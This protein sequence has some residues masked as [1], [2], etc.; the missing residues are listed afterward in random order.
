M[1]DEQEKANAAFLRQRRNLIAGALLILFLETTVSPP[2]E[3]H[4]TGIT[5]RITHAEYVIYWIW[6]FTT[7]WLL[8][9][10]QYL[11]PIVDI[12][13][14]TKFEHEKSLKRLLLRMANK[15][16]LGAGGKSD[17]ETY[18]YSLQEPDLLIS[19]HGITHLSVAYKSVFFE[20]KADGSRGRTAIKGG[21]PSFRL[22]FLQ[23]LYFNV[24]AAIATAVRTPL[25]TD[26]V[27]PILLFLGGAL[28]SAH[29]IL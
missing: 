11:P 12:L 4:I 28:S 2:D 9:F 15:H 13:E 24:L 22:N 26:Y 25:F 5:L 10:F 21:F 19:R 8:R 14:T 6:L 7:Y 20:K 27:I 18:R 29:R 1:S 3:I 16:R 17:D 23:A